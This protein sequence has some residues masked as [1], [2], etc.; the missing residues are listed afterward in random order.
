MSVQAHSFM[1]WLVLLSSQV[2][3]FLGVFFLPWGRLVRTAGQQE[4]S[5]F[6]RNPVE[7]A[8]RCWLLSVFAAEIGVDIKTTGTNNWDQQLGELVVT[9]LFASYCLG[10]ATCRQSAGGFWATSLVSMKKQQKESKSAKLMCEKEIEK[11]K[12]WVLLCVNIRR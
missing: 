3:G 8:F 12:F 10:C 2:G 5:R 4:A 6:S 7:S 1:V 11:R 9:S